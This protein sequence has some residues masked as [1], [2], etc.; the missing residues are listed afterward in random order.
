MTKT[1]LIVIVGAAALGYWLVAVM[2]PHLLSPPSRKP[3][4]PPVPDGPLW[5]DILGVSPHAS[6]DDIVAAYEAK[7]HEYAP[8]RMAHLGPDVRELARSRREQLGL[9]YDAA[10]RDLEWL[11]PRD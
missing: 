8:E 3:S 2:L 5:H 9:A 6:R 10:L 11:R 7:I 1:E 4:P